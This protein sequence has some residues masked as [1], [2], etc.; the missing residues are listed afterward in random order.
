MIE[1]EIKAIVREVLREELRAWSSPRLPDHLLSADE[2]ARVL[3][4]DDRQS[5]YRLRREG[6]LKAIWV[7]EKEFKFAPEVVQAFIDQGGVKRADSAD[8]AQ[9]A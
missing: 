9:A 5:V 4:F 2:V 3:G 7:S 8:I 1:D 6:H